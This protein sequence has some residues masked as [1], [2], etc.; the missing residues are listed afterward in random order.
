MTQIVPFPSNVD[1]FTLFRDLGFKRLVPVIPP[2]A[3]ISSRSNLS[4]RLAMGR[5]DRG[6]V[7]GQLWPDGTWSGMDWINAPEPSPADLERWQ[8]WGAGVGIRTGDLGDGTSLVMIDADTLEEPLARTIKSIVETTVGKLPIRVGRFPKAGYL[9]RVR[10][11][12]RYARVSFGA[13]DVPEN[14]RERV[15]ILSD[16]KFMV[17]L[18]LHQVTKQP[19]RWPAEPPRLEDVPVLDADVLDRMME[20]LRL[21][22]P[23]AGRVTKEGSAG[24][25]E[26]DQASLRGD[27]ETV[28]KAVRALPNTSAHF[29]EREDWLGV[30]YMIK[31][32]M[33]PDHEADGLALFHEWSER[34]SDPPIEQ[35]KA[36]GNA[37]EYVEAEW[38][39]MKPPFRAGASKLWDLSAR[40]SGGKFGLGDVW[41]EEPREPL[42]ADDADSSGNGIGSSRFYEVLTLDQIENLPDPEFLIDRH[43]QEN[44]F[45]FVYGDPGTGK[46][47]IALDWALSIVFGLSSWHG[48]SIKARPNAKVLYLAGEGAAG[49]KT[50]VLAWKKAR[51]LTGVSDGGRFNLVR[52]PCNFM[53]AEDVTK[54]K[55]TAAEHIGGHIDFTVI[56]TVSRSSPGAGENETKDMSLFVAAAESIKRLTGGVVLGVHHANKQGGFRG[57]TA[58][59]GAGDFVFKLERKKG[60]PVGSLICEKQ[61]DAPDGWDE[62]YAFEVVSLDNG[63]SSLVPRRCEAHV[64]PETA[65]TPDVAK[66]VLAAIAAAWEAGEPWSLASNAKVRAVTRMV[67][68]FSFSADKA[69]EMVRLWLGMG[70]I[71]VEQSS[72]K[73]HRKGLRVVGEI[74][75]DES[76]EIEVDLFD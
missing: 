38:G 74:G 51:G 43:L 68:D 64:G 55:T 34:W 11:S 26:V 33:G 27:P 35:G 13:E 16:G 4:K 49:F 23:N 5:D 73:S 2:D 53:K 50:R 20:A 66:S 62:P 24:G 6:K 72:G 8:R 17:A 10:G 1:G 59:T 32:A 65:L 52:A 30:G 71:K 31:A 28:A 61:K 60:H 15:E 67:Q 19:Y 3:P 58:L 57:S 7:P 36:Y 46:S 39:R 25:A 22:L 70:L 41:F 63:R 21:V 9:A 75:L 37:P 76:A 54:L 45:G 56:D 42:F 18:G 14:K 48:D 29:P 12:Y 69:D 40:L 44:T 47:F